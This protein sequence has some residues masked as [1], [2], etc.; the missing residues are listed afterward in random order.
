MGKKMYNYLLSSEI[1]FIFISVCISE[2][3]FK[4][5][6]NVPKVFISL[7]GCIMDGLI[8]ILSKSRIIFENE[9]FL[10]FE[11]FRKHLEVEN[12]FI[13]TIAG[14]KYKNNK[15]IEMESL[16]EDLDHDPSEGQDWNW[17]DYE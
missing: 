5:T 16:N 13:V 8:S 15:I 9:E 4:I 7:T 17:E 11:V 14:V 3:K 2:C 6:L 12:D 1:T 10:C